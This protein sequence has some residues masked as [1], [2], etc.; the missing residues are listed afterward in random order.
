MD[1][2]LDSYLFA[3][4][5]MRSAPVERFLKLLKHRGYVAEKDTDKSLDGA[6][7]FPDW[8]LPKSTQAPRCLVLI[9]GR[10]KSTILISDR[11]GSEAEVYVYWRSL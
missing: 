7:P 11:N 5:S 3:N 4:L 1:E 9:R 10:V 8:W 6:P 2:A